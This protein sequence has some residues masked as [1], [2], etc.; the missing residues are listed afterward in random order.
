VADVMFHAPKQQFKTVWW[1]AAYCRL[2]PSSAD[3]GSKHLS[4]N[5]AMTQ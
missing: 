1:V 4:I 3:A 2:K 5:H